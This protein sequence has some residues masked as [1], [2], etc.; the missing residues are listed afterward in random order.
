[1]KFVLTFETKQSDYTGVMYLAYSFL[2]FTTKLPPYVIYLKFE[3][4]PIEV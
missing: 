2:R 1:M 4:I 3:L